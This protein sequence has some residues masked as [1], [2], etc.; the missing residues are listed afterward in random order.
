M[1]NFSWSNSGISDI[2]HFLFNIQGLYFKII[3]L[4]L[5]KKPFFPLTFS[6]DVFIDI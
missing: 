1:N 6:F 5:E 3:K 4:G 2:N